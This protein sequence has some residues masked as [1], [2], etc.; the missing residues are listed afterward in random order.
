MIPHQRRAQSLVI[1]MCPNGG[2]FYRCAFGYQDCCLIDACSVAGGCPQ[3]KQTNGQDSS[4][5]TTASQKIVATAI[6]PTLRT[7]FTGTALASS[8]LFQSSLSR[9]IS[10][11]AATSAMRIVTSTSAGQTVYVIIG[12]TSTL[13]ALPVSDTQSRSNVPKT[14][15]VGGALGGMI[16]IALVSLLIFCIKRR[17]Q[18]K[19][20]SAPTYPSSSIDSDMS[21]HLPSKQIL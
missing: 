19:I 8:T 11:S 2:A 17:R 12:P 10:L 18:K 1:G 20:Y 15:I 4:N 14:A 7:S 6:K 13:T 9:I 3:S 5:S 21:R 16:V